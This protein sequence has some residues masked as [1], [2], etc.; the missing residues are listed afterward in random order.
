[1][2]VA[3]ALITMKAII[4]AAG[5][6]SR[7]DDSPD[8][9]P[10]ALTLLTPKTSIL[11]FQ[12][13]ALTAYLSLDQI[14]IV[15]GYQKEAIM[16]AFPDLVY[17]YNP[18]FQKE[19]TSKSLLR[20]LNKIDEDILWLNGDVV[21]RPAILESLLKTA[22]TAMIVNQAVVGEEEVKYRTD[23]Q[24]L[25]LEVSK[26]VIQP[27]GEALGINF[28]KRED[29]PWLRKHLTLCKSGDFFEKAIEK[30]IREGH[31]VRSS[32]VGNEDCAEIDFPEDL[33]RAKQLMLLWG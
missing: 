26:E 24:G 9:P 15:V 6:G 8:H 18:H 13:Q 31:H 20:A 7:L 11:A 2:A 1:M 19:N 28:F 32:P 12:L 10:K 33:I 30:G 16:D 22:R 27:Q 5:S 29:L 21:F 17:I 4:L 14:W 3:S 25:I 23:D